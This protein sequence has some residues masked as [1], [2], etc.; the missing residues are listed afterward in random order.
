M[1]LDRGLRLPPA[2]QPALLR[3]RGLVSR[4]QRWPA[5]P[6]F[7]PALPAL[8]GGLEQPD[9][10]SCGSSVLVAMEL[11]LRDSRIDTVRGFADSALAMRLQTNAALDRFGRFQLPWPAVLGT[12]PAALIRQLGNDWGHRWVNRVVDPFNP[13]RAYDAILATVAANT[14]VPLYVGEGSWMQHIVLV[15]GGTEDWLDIYDPACGEVLRRTRAQFET[16]TLR[17]AGW[18]QPWLVILPHR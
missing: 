2:V 1:R 3:V 16:A 18:D 7:R 6:A 12:R 9:S 17:I 10:T 5:P 15:V 11:L 14:P 4:A 13:T 8:P